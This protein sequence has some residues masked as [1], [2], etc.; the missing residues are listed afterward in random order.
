M[1]YTNN[2]KKKKKKSKRKHYTTETMR[3]Q[4]YICIIYKK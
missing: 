3:S 1:N 4:K 2:T